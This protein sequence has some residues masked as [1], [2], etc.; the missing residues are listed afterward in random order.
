MPTQILSAG[1][2]FLIFIILI[3]KQNRLR[4]PGE[5]F[6]LYCILYSMKRF[7]VEFFRG[8]NPKIFFGL[9][10]SQL[11]SI[12]IFVAVVFI[13]RSKVKKWKNATTTSR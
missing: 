7:A 4:F 12:G 3:I 10:I 1:L 9:T 5:I 11:V 13:F 2:L 6:L 8:D